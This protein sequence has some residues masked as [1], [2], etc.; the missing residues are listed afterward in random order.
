MLYFEDFSDSDD[1]SEIYEEPNIES[2]EKPKQNEFFMIY[3]EIRKICH[4]N[5]EKEFLLANALPVLKV[6]APEI[7]ADIAN[8]LT[9]HLLIT[10]DDAVTLRKLGDLV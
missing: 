9:T 5:S 3:S 1:N 8:L 7:P 10:E 6:V 2:D 4:R